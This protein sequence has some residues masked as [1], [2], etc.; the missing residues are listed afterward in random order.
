MLSLN[1]GAESLVYDLFQNI[2]LNGAHLLQFLLY[3]LL[4]GQLVLRPDLN[5]VQIEVGRL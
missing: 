3:C 5:Q 4:S 2:A 1:G